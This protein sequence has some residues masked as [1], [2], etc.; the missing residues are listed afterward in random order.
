VFVEITY[1]VLYF[2]QNELFPTQVRSLAILLSAI[3]GNLGTVFIPLIANLNKT[4]HFVLPFTYFM[5]GIIIIFA[6]M[7]I[8]ETY[9]VPPPEI[10]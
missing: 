8:R 4:T 1:Q 10:I 9:G 3:I 6:T 5:S 7:Q 2:I